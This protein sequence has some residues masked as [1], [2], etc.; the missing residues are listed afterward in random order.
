MDALVSIHDV[1]PS[2]LDRVAHLL[3]RCDHHRI[4][5]VTL[6]VVPGLRWSADDLE[7]LRHW[8]RAGHELA[9]HG[10]C[11]RARTPRTLYHRLHA[12]VISRDCAEHLSRPRAELVD[13]MHA[14]HDWF[15]CR[16]L[17]APSLYVPPA[18]ALGPVG[19]ADL[20]TLP[21]A[22]VETLGGLRRAGG[23]R[24]LPLVGY[25][26]DTWTRSAALRAS[27]AVARAVRGVR[28]LRIGLHPDD[29]SLR[30]ADDLEADLAG[31]T[32]SLHYRELAETA[33]GMRGT[34]TAAGSG[35]IR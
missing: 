12:A 4:E 9:A 22:H 31:V 28:P 24:R 16:G 8:Q 7:R 34:D 10:W 6:L 25:E 15:A 1:T 19:D 23:F 29:A 26:A 32:R 14:S 27:N 5:R 13:L 11:H 33:P 20:A 18:W 21:F 17:A 2:T 30:L 35:R 3:D